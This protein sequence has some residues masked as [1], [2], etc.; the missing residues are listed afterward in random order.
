MVSYRKVSKEDREDFKDML[1]YAFQ[2][3][4]RE[5]DH[6]DDKNYWS[7]IGSPR[8]I[9]RG[10]DLL[11]VSSIHQF[12]SLLRGSW[13]PGSG[14]TA[15]ATP[16]ENRHRGYIKTIMREI[17]GELK[18]KDVLVSYL[19]PFLYPFYD[20][21]GW[22][23]C[24]RYTL[25]ELE[26]ENL[27]FAAETGSGNFR[28]VKGEDYE[29]IVSTYRN[30]IRDFNLPIRR[31]SDWWKYQLLSPW[32]RTAYCYL[33]EKKGK[34]KGYTIY[35]VEKGK[36]GEWKKKL[37]VQEIIYESPEAYFQL[38]R[39]LYNHGSQMSKIILPSPLPEGLSLLDLVEDPREIEAREKPGIMVRCVDVKATLEALSYRDKPEGEL[40][41]TVRD[42]LI[43]ANDG[44]YR[45]VFNGSS[46]PPEITRTNLG[47][48][49]SDL[50]LAIGSLTQ[51]CTGYMSPREAVVAGKVSL[52][53][54]DKLSLLEKIFPGKDTF[55]LD[56]F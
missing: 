23:V 13:L 48:M 40:L 14:V 15:V 38:L 27:K 2:P 47:S 50:E 31:S 4:K 37:E 20:K 1:H 28:R 36:E 45:V 54:E 35:S 17:L 41:M 30:F 16:P 21:L 24:D 19:W 25:Y 12:E 34:V 7:R 6:R 26:P 43:D 10:D 22:R 32:H 8:G 46:S 5:Q 51:L 56:G 53:N 18:Q 11:A 44:K 3:H 29:D 42:P 55:F 52:K 33:W 49:Q 39:F 9:Y